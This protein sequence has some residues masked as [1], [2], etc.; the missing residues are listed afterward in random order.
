MSLDVFYTHHYRSASAA[1]YDF[2][3]K[4]VGKK[5]ADN[6]L[7][8]I[9][10]VVNLIANNPYMFKSSNFDKNVRVGLVNRRHSLLYTVSENNI[11]ILFIWDNK[12]EPLF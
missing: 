4:N 5:A 8:N 1:I 3:E 11:Y 9:D 2:I 7:I 12:Q 10:K 6:F